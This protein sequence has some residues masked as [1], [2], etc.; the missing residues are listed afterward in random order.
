MEKFPNWTV[1]YN[2]A[3]DFVGTGWEKAEKRYNELSLLPAYCP[4][5]R[6]FHKNDI[7]HM[8][9]IHHIQKFNKNKK[10]NKNQEF[11]NYANHLL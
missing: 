9:A 2:I 5:K 1:L 3:G 6:P 10:F 7:K 8:G 11:L 4:T